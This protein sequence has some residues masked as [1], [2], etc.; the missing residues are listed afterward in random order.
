MPIYDFMCST[1]NETNERMV[2]ISEAESQVC[3]VCS[4]PLVKLISP[5]HFVLDG[6]DSGF[7]TAY[8]NWARQR[9]GIKSQF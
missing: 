1:C 3:S 9:S 5:A 8:A 7:P 4:K 6:T 2:S